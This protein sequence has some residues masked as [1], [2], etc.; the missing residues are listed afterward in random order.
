ML[1]FFFNYFLNWLQQAGFHKYDHT[2]EIQVVL[3]TRSFVLSFFFF[4]LFVQTNLNQSINLNANLT[5]IFDLNYPF[6]KIIRSSFVFECRTLRSL[7]F[8]PGRCITYGIWKRVL[9]KR[10]LCRSIPVNFSQLIAISP[11]E[12]RS[13]RSRSGRRLSVNNVTHESLDYPLK[14]P[15]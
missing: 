10:V 13:K 6:Y 12:Q 7:P 8:H 3:L 1:L 2:I 5:L 9:D 4:L 11:L 15:I 14:W